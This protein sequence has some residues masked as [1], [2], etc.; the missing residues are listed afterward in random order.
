MLGSP[1]DTSAKDRT[2]LALDKQTNRWNPITIFGRSF[3]LQAFGTWIVFTE[4]HH[5]LPDSLKWELLE[6]QRSEGFLSAAERFRL[7][8]YPPTGRLHYYNVRSG[9]LHVYDTGEPNS[10]ALYVDDQDRAYLRVS[11]ELWRIRINED[12]SGG[13]TVLAKQ[14]ELWAV[15]WLVMGSP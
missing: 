6:T 5:D 14:P 2:W 11:D 12:G 4:R 15:H 9:R 3:S 8:R 10:E 13:V 1:V 7:H